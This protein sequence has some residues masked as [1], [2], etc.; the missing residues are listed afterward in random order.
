MLLMVKV[1]SSDSLAFTKAPASS[2]PA[3]VALPQQTSSMLR[4]HFE[5]LARSVLSNLPKLVEPV[6]G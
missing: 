1:S 3:A 2:K 5:D 6:Q 4:R